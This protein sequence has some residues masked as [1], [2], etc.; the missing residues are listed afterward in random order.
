LHDA[1]ETQSPNRIL[2]LD[3]GIAMQLRLLSRDRLPLK[4]APQ[5]T[6][7]ERYFVASIRQALAEPRT[8]FAGYDPAVALVNPR[9]RQL[10]DQAV[11]DAGR[12]MR[13]GQLVRDRQG[14]PLFEIL[15]TE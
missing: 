12:R 15:E 3:W 9:T 13:R 11:G 4:E 14:R 2:V 1:L 5:P 8:V 6:G 10:L 7:E